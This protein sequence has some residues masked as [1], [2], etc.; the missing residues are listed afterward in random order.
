VADIESS[1]RGCALDDLVTELVE[2]R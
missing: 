2:A 1:A